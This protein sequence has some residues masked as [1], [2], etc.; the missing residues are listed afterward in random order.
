[1]RHRRANALTQKDIE[2]GRLHYDF[3]TTSDYNGKIKFKEIKRTL[4]GQTPFVVKLKEV[5]PYKSALADGMM[6]LADHQS[7]SIT[8]SDILYR[9]FDE[10]PDIMHDLHNRFT[11][12]LAVNHA[13]QKSQA[14]GDIL[15]LVSAAEAKTTAKMLKSVF[16]TLYKFIF[17]L[18][19]AVKHLDPKEAYQILSD[20]WLSYRYGWTPLVME[21]QALYDNF[22]DNKLFEV[23]SAYGG[24][25]HEKLDVE[26]TKTLD[27]LDGSFEF[28]GELHL[29]I[30]S[31]I[32]RTGFNYFNSEESRNGSALA[33]LGLDLESILSTAWELIPFSFILDMFVNVGDSLT[34]LNVQAEVNPINGY[35]TTHLQCTVGYNEK[36][37]LFSSGGVGY[38]LSGRVKHAGKFVVPGTHGHFN[39]GRQY[40]KVFN[41]DTLHSWFTAVLFTEADLNEG[42]YLHGKLKL[43]GSPKIDSSMES[44]YHDKEGNHHGGFTNI[45]CGYYEERVYDDGQILVS[46]QVVPQDVLDMFCEKIVSPT[47][48][49]L[50]ELKDEYVNLY[51]PRPVDAP[52]RRFC[53]ERGFNTHGFTVYRPGH[54]ALGTSP[55][56]HISQYYSA[57]VL[58]N[59]LY[60]IYPYRGDP[61]ELGEETLPARGFTGE[62]TQRDEHNHF[63]FKM[64]ADLDLSKSQVTDLIIFG[65]RLITAIRKKLKKLPYTE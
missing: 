15:L 23:R 22:N 24:Q 10:N 52:F 45:T 38:K 11:D 60:K 6:A 39:Y 19:K 29:K 54:M 30:Q 35:K 16:I 1:M 4:K 58:A 44:H 13:I 64:V 14:Y 31:V 63:D 8:N 25:K 20:A 53:E 26:Y 17:G 43:I 5:K 62:F 3:Q 46:A 42:G 48:D 59:N 37:L 34:A 57:D 2:R 7:S 36:K 28:D 21:L 27:F 47:L 33:R 49:Q 18:Y 50:F 56:W 61:Y 55:S 41:E 40:S 12:Q 9:L 51:G 32:Y 65:E